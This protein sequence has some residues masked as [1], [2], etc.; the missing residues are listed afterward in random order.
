MG[1]LSV[2]P[3]GAMAI[4]SAS[5]WEID[6][7]WTRDGDTASLLVTADATGEDGSTLLALNVTGS[8]L[9]VTLPV[10]APF[11]LTCE[12]ARGDETPRTVTLT[13]EGRDGDM[14]VR[15]TVPDG[16]RIRVEGTLLPWEPE[17]W[18]QWKNVIDGTWNIF[19]LYE[20][21][22]NDFVNAIARP[23]LTGAI[24]L[25]AR[26]PVNVCV[27]LMDLATQAGLFQILQEPGAEA[28]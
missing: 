3:R 12:V 11:T 2:F 28:Y 24:P 14:T 22:L 25:L 1:T 8:G 23:M 19:S 16:T 26:T 10:N 5:S 13:G 20:Y 6:W 21:S 18:P 17:S 9:P 7:Q 27:T 4:L 15:L